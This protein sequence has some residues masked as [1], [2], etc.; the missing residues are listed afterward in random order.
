MKPPYPSELLLGIALGA[1]MTGSPRAIERL[2]QAPEHL[3]RDDGAAGARAARKIIIS[4][5][6]D[7]TE[8]SAALGMYCDPRFDALENV[9]NELDECGVKLAAY[10]LAGR[11][12]SLASDH[13]FRAE[14]SMLATAAEAMAAEL[15]AR[16][17]GAK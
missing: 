2:R 10:A 4:E 17:G 16:A 15:R 12:Q 7:A 14:L 11:V 9:W 1:A 5:Q 3:F 8:I 6:P 13:A